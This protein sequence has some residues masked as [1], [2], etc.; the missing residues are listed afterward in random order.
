MCT[1]SYFCVES[2]RTPWLHFLRCNSCFTFTRCYRDWYFPCI[3]NILTIH[4]IEITMWYVRVWP[5]PCLHIRHLIISVNHVFTYW[6]TNVCLRCWTVCQ[7]LSTQMSMDLEW[8][9]T[10][11]H[12]DVTFTF[13]SNPTNPTFH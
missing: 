3:F 13:Q 2:N 10:N 5:L 1:G 8:W 7:K 12:I 4:R 11:S 9:S 6:H